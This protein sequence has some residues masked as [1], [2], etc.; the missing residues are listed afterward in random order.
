MVNDSCLF[1]TLVY[2]GYSCT[3][4]HLVCSLFLDARS[5][6]SRGK[7]CSGSGYSS[8]T[9]D[10]RL[11]RHDHGNGPQCIAGLDCVRFSSLGRRRRRR[12]SR[13][14]YRNIVKHCVSA[15]W[16]ICRQQLKRPKK[17]A[18]LRQDYIVILDWIHPV[19]SY[20]AFQGPARRQT[21]VQ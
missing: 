2:M 14:T 1:H 15:R 8:M 20:Q 10:P 17:A 18:A 6:C 4:T 13:I 19:P 12:Y 3:Q 21:C 9:A 7:S 5:A 16:D 11:S